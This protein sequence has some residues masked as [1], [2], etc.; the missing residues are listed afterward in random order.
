MVYNN[1]IFNK[2]LNLYKGLTFFDKNYFLIN[3]NLQ[4]N[5]NLNKFI[6]SNVLKYNIILY[7]IF[8]ILLLKNL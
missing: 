2:S 3:N 6:M 1:S 4:I 7:K 5:F 8:I